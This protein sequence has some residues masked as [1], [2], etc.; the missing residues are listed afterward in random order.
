MDFS[1]LCKEVIRH[2]FSQG[3]WELSPTGPLFSYFSSKQASLLHWIVEADIFIFFRPNRY[4]AS[5]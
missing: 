3:L 2:T 4:L 5:I 1:G